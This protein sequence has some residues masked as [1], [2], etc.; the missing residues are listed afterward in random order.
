MKCALRISFFIIHNKFVRGEA[1]RAYF[2]RA[3]TLRKRHA[4][5]TRNAGNLVQ[6]YVS[7]KI[8]EVLSFVMV[9]TVIRSVSGVHL[10][11]EHDRGDHI[12]CLERKVQYNYHG[13]FDH[14]SKRHGILAQRASCACWQPQYRYGQRSYDP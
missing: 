4:L 1:A 9:Y 12:H 6:M 10:R 14:Y 11:G 3:K 8:E 2:E 5:T 7:S 13:L